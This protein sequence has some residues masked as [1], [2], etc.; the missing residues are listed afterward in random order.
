[1]TSGQYPNGYTPYPPGQTPNSAYSAL[2][3][4]L[5]S[6][7]TV[8]FVLAIIGIFTGGLILGPIA[9][10]WGNSILSQAAANGVSPEVVKN[11]SRGKTIGMVITILYAAIL[12][13]VLFIMGLSLPNF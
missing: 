4:K 10:I 2:Q 9:W 5:R 3:E 11:A 12:V 7:S 1:M 8:V 13:V 6:N